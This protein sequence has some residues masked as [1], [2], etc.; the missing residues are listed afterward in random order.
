MLHMSSSDFS[1]TQCTRDIEPPR[2][3]DIGSAYILR[4]A[5]GPPSNPRR[6]TDFDFRFCAL[7]KCFAKATHAK[8]CFENQSTRRKLP[9]S[10]KADRG[11]ASLFQHHPV[12]SLKRRASQGCWKGLRRSDFCD[13]RARR[14]GVVPEFLELRVFLAENGAE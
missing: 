10:F 13:L 4:P 1:G 9:P 5:A 11:G 6:V 14:S 8:Q 3:P 12:F 2:D 7:R